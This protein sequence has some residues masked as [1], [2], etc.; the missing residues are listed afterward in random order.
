MT[1]QHTPGPWKPVYYPH[2]DEIQ[3]VYNDAGNWLASVWDIR[4]TEEAWADAHL[5]AAAPDMFKVLRELEY[6]F[7]TDADILEKMSEDERRNNERQLAKI[8]A[9]IAKARGLS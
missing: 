1:A 7:T 6:W 4:D 9:A 2:N 5:I 3:I 8:R